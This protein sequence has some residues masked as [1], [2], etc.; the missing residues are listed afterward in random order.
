MPQR[1][2]SCGRKRI[3][4]RIAAQQVHKHMR[5]IRY[6]CVHGCDMRELYTQTVP[7]NDGRRCHAFQRE[8]C[9]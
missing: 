1:M 5:H 3:A 7:P 4:E 9:E 6:A 8:L 2:P